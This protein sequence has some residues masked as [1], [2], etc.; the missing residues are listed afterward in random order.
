MRRTEEGSIDRAIIIETKGEGFAA[1]FADRRRF[2]QDVFVSMNEKKF[3]Y[4]R[5]GFL[6]IEDSMTENQRRIA[7]INAIESFFKS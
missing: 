3:G 7:T 6:Y 4:R 5:F 1:K 2:M